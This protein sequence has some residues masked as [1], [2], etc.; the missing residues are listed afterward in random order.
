MNSLSLIISLQKSIIIAFLQNATIEYSSES[1][2][3]CPCLCVRV[4]ARSLSRSRNMR[5]EY[6]VAYE[7][8]SNEFD[9]ELCWIKV[10]VTVG[11]KSFL[12]LPQYKLSGPI[13]QLWYKLG[14]LCSA[15]ICSSDT[16]TKFMNIITLE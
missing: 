8:S 15:C 3:V 16:N 10:K 11:F 9:I 7:D 14:S 1:L 4:C 6:I 12:H 5:L 13:T 2:C